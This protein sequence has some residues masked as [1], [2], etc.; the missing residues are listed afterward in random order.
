ME[1][2][3]P[4]PDRLRT[5]PHPLE[6]PAPIRR[7]GFPT[8]T[9][10]L[11]DET[12]KKEKKTR[13]QT[14]LLASLGD[15]HPY[16]PPARV[17]PSVG[18]QPNRPPSQAQ[19][20]VQDGNLARSTHRRGRQRPHHC[21]DAHAPALR[22]PP[23]WTATTTPTT[24]PP[25]A[26]ASILDG[27]VPTKPLTH[28]PPLYAHLP[29]ERR[30]PPHPPTRSSTTIHVDGNVPHPYADAPAPASCEPSCPAGAARIPPTRRELLRRRSRR[31]DGNLP[32]QIGSASSAKLLPPSHRSAVTWTAPL[33]L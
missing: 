27:N 5:F 9:H 14:S 26:S 29:C 32:P 15:E 22:S 4:P 33:D 16:Q 10:S 21:A 12:D 6:I 1:S 7:P 13:T 2:S 3:G 17:R 30:R 11:G 18:Q 8:A 20:T 23:V 25:Q 28:T 19:S 24:R 31:G